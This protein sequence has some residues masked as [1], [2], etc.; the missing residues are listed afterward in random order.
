MNQPL[1]PITSPAPRR[2][3]LLL[4][5]LLAI[6]PN[7]S[8]E[9]PSARLRHEV[10]LPVPARSAE[11]P[12]RERLLPEPQGVQYAL[13]ARTVIP[14]A[15]NHQ[16]D[17]KSSY[18]RFRS[19]EA[20]YDFFYTSRDSLTPRL[21]I[22]NQFDEARFD[23]IVSRARD[24]AVQLALE[25]RFF[26]TTRLDLAVG[27]DATEIDDDLGNNPFVALDLRYPLWVSREK[28]ER[29]SEDIF[30]RNELDDAQLAYIQ[31]VRS[32]LQDVLFR[33]HDV[34]QRFRTVEN[35][36][37]WRD[38]LLALR[39]TVNDIA[40]RDATSDRRRLEAEIARVS[41][42][43]RTESGWYDIQ[44]GRF[45]AAVGMPFHAE[46]EFI[47]EP[48]NPFAGMT[49]QDV[50]Q[51]S[52]D[53]D[54]EIATLRNSVRNAEV[55]LDLARRGRW[56]AALLLGA[57]SDLE[58]GG[59]REGASDWSV[60]VGLDLSAVDPR[61]TDSLVRQAEANIRRFKQAIVARENAI[62]VDTLE[63]IVRIDTVGASRQD[64]IRNLPRYVEDYETG[65]TDYQ[66]DR[67]NVEE[68]LIRR[69]NLFNQQQEVSS[70]TFLLGANVAELLSATGKFF[71]LL[72]GAALSRPADPAAEGKRAPN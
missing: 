66:A 65:V 1:R 58:G 38:D 63:P 60:A 54:P 36:R 15:F 23:N 55:Q 26:D 31:Q 3:H 56:D 21:R 48:F 43:F 30:R 35:Y 47:E 18:E 24:H 2:V 49:H 10:N 14:L 59:S 41:A 62:Y 52:I 33:F 39:T 68:L 42:N 27:I 40:D 46:V 5:S 29:T 11:P 8:R 28:L 51:A 64:L 34:I 67:L 19:E 22:D 25:K 32:R 17:I 72:D 45:K 37:Q 6:G 61:V 50:L 13:S 71:E 57:E 44:L 4:V 20:R 69:Q 16:P 9:L 7:C 12:G 70:L 53:T